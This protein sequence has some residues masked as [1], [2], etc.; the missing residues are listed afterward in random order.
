MTLGAAPPVVLE[1]APPSVPR[2]GPPFEGGSSSSDGGSGASSSDGTGPDGTLSRREATLRG[3]GGMA[4]AGGHGLTR[5]R[6][7]VVAHEGEDLL[8]EHLL[9]HEVCEGQWIVATPDYDVYRENYVS[10]DI[11]W[12]VSFFC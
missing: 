11:I 4:T 7:A 5:L 9:M 3:E 1:G 12:E 8:Y 2:L 6:R 10:D